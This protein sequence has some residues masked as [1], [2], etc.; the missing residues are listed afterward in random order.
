M[1]IIIVGNHIATYARAS[2]LDEGKSF[3]E[4]KNEDLYY[5]PVEGRKKV[6]IIDED[7]NRTMDEIMVFGEGEIA[8]CDLIPYPEFYETDVILAHMQEH[9]ILSP[10]GLLSGGPT[11]SAA[12][13][14]GKWIWA[15]FPLLLALGVLIYAFI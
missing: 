7:G 5:T 15:Y 14:I 8:P 3:Y 12:R 2:Y 1:R 9:K 4:R 6:T 10:H 11:W 13:Q